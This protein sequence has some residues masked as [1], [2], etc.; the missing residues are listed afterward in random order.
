VQ[1][2]DYQQV[3]ASAV[4]RYL[5]E[6]PVLVL[7]TG[8]GKTV[9]AAHIVRR[10]TCRTLWLAHRRE[11]IAQAA[12]SLRRHGLEVGEILAGTDP[13][14]DAPVQVASVQTLL[15]RMHPPA[16]LVVID[17][18][19][20][21]RASSYERIVDLYPNARFLGLTATPFRLDGQGLGTP[22]GRIVVG[23]YT[24]DLCRQGYLVEPIVYAPDR[25]RI[26]GA[27]RRGGD[28]TERQQVEA[29]RRPAITGNVVRTWMQRSRDRRTAVF[30]VNIEHSRWIVREFRR[31][32]VRAEHLDGST[33]RAQRDAILYRLRTGY[34]RVVSQCNVLSEG[35][36]L[37][38]L[39][40]AIV[41]RPT[42][43]LCL[44]LQMIGRVMRA[45][46]GKAG[47][48]V[49][50]HA[51][52]HLRHGVVTQRLQY[53]LSDRVTPESLGG[54]TEPGPGR[55]CPECYL[56]VPPGVPECPGCGHEYRVQRPRHVEGDLVRLR[57]EA[58]LEDQQR[59][60]ERIDA[61]RQERG[62]QEGWSFHR[63]TALYGFAPLVVDGQVVRP[64]DATRE[65]R[66]SVFLKLEARRIQRG[67]K[68]GWTGVQY[69]AVFGEWPTFA[70]ASAR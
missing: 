68:P 9:T 12:A 11:L 10:L 1:L 27:P 50:D 47:A 46:D 33:P 6:R 7:P 45:A 41:A 60:W 59:A 32:G 58:P 3:A 37:P 31:R 15:R 13:T 30:A 8:A 55:R 38:A 42:A 53:S 29:M 28:Y 52:N 5:S 2:R 61:Q 63:F 43:S 69:R 14:P 4:L 19:H 39:D 20:H 66:E 40:T 24:D 65:Q 23:A 64:E 56:I 49:L 62:Y 16:D 17:E 18:A 22:F 25:P 67:Y 36:D 35:W 26:A 51:G 70:R 21:V 57:R 34:T 54:D 48:L 44:H